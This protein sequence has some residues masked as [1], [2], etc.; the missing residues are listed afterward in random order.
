MTSGSVGSGSVAGT[1][2]AHSSTTMD[3][4]CCSSIS[5]SIDSID[6]VL[7]FNNNTSIS[8]T[9]ESFDLIVSSPSS[10]SVG[11]V[12]TAPLAK[13]VSSQQEDSTL[14][15]RQQPLA[16]VCSK[17][18]QLLQP[19][20]SLLKGKNNNSLSSLDM[21]TSS[22]E[23]LYDVQDLS[24]VSVS[25]GGSSSL[26]AAA[27][28]AKVAAT[29]GNSNESTLT[30]VQGLEKDISQKQ[31]APKQAPAADKPPRVRK[32]SWIASIG[33]GHPKVA[34]GSS[35]ST[36]TAG[37]SGIG[38]GGS[39]YSPAV[40]KLLAIFSPSNLFSSNKSSPPSSECGTVPVGSTVAGTLGSGGAGKENSGP[41]VNPPARKESPM[42][43]LFRW[44][45]KS[46]STAK[47]EE[48]VL[49]VNISPENT[50]TPQG[51][52]QGL[53]Q[54]QQQHSPQS[55]AATYNVD[56]IPSQLKAEIKENISPENTITNSKLL[57]NPSSSPTTV[58]PVVTGATAGVMPAAAATVVPIHPKV[59]FHLGDDYDESEDD[60]DT[61]TNKYGG[62]PSSQQPPTPSLGTSTSGTEG[63]PSPSVVLMHT[64]HLG[65]LARDSLT[66]MFKN[67]SLASQDSIRSM[68]SLTEMAAAE[69]QQQKPAAP[70]ED[71][72]QAQ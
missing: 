59:I 7:Q 48:K 54:Q 13:T 6:R 25:S 60:I 2:R 27:A 33:G 8:S 41:P 34:D 36:L 67:P 9:D 4:S 51:Q 15:P 42:G 12:S 38:S 52:G 61:I 53:F 58:Q 31:A 39:T 24:S 14:V 26:A 44:T 3:D 19:T 18:Q 66:T 69:Q 17:E 10:S 22:Q 5:S 1:A 29:C 68:D 64:S 62:K 46:S 55:V 57:L 65:Q 45:T 50:I 20:A 32:T 23:S 49:K 56:N 35:S 30:S 63:S 37:N 47:D 71:N 16:A 70:Q 43:G 11:S 28:T 40:E 21:S 72:T